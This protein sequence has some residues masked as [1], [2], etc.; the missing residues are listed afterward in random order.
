MFQPS[1]PLH[2]QVR[3]FG[4]GERPIADLARLDAAGFAK[5]EDLR[6]APHPREREP[7]LAVACQGRLGFSSWYSGVHLLRGG[8]CGFDRRSPTP[9]ML[10][11]AEHAHLAYY[12]V[13]HADVV[14]RS[15]LIGLVENDRLEWFTEDETPVAENEFARFLLRAALSP[16]HQG[17]AAQVSIQFAKLLASVAVTA[18]DVP[19]GGREPRML[20][21]PMFVDAVDYLHNEHD[22]VQFHDRRAGSVHETYFC[23]GLTD[24]EL[25]TY[26]R[27]RKDGMLAAQAEDAAR[28]VMV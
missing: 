4:L 13:R 8:V 24:P 16:E 20:V 26:I 19:A 9:V 21:G 15:G 5:L 27:L 22:L 7:Q 3:V 17:C 14:H 6:D 25:A 23:P 1:F 28:L 12:E 11:R 10:A 2:E 18:T